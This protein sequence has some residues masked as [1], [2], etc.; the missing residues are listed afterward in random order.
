[1]ADLFL[2]YRTQRQSAIDFVNAQLKLAYLSVPFVS[3]ATE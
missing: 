3:L 2:E 1:M